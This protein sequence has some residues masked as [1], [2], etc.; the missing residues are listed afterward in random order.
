MQQ[1]T[2]KYCNY[3]GSISLESQ[4]HAGHVVNYQHTVEDTREVLN[5]GHVPKVD[6][7]RI[8]RGLNVVLEYTKR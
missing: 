6:K 3:V 5:D 2:Q 7:E 4:P 1:H 8:D